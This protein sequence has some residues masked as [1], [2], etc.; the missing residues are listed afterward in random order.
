[1]YGVLWFNYFLECIRLQILSIASALFQVQLIKASPVMIACKTAKL[2]MFFHWS[3]EED[4]EILIRYIN[5]FSKWNYKL[6]N[7]GRRAF[8]HAHA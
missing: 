8:V 5:T 1:M 6:V 2:C 4:S 3:I 7:D